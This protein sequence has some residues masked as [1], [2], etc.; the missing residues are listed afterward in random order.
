MY[1]N[2]AFFTNCQF[3]RAKKAQELYHAL[4][5]PSIND[6]KAILR[7]NI[8]ANDPVTIEDIK[9][10]KQIFGSNIGSLKGKTTR[11]KL[12]PVVDD[13]I[14]IPE[15]LYAKQQDIVLCIDGI[16]VNG[17][18][19]LTTVSKNI[20]YQTAQYVESKSISQFKEALK[21]IIMLY[22]KAGFKIKEI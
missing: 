5:M 19:F 18:L 14:A 9:I 12:I 16:K 21:E 1:E 15:E 13:Y 7:M 10:A 22:N 11:Q 17:M 6:F 4:E 2:K 20:L 3:A 8:I